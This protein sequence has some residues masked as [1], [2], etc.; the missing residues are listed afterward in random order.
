MSEF[1]HLRQRAVAFTLL[2]GFALFG[3][4]LPALGQDAPPARLRGTIDSVDG[5]LLV[6]KL[7][8][9]ASLKVRL[10]EKARISALVKASLA[11]VKPGT[12][13]GITSVPNDKGGQKALEIHVFPEAMRGR[14]EGQRPWDLAPQT[15]MTNGNIDLRVDA[16]AGSDLTLS[17]KGGTAKIEVPPDTTIVAFAESRPDDLRPGNKVIVFGLKKREDGVLE[18]AAIAIGRD[19]LTPP[20]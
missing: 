3:G 6:I 12:F 8:E 16:V 20:M 11:D 18:A 17:F 14:S 5:R 9:G 1:S 13:V 15:T 19:G 2:F 4:I 7:R 10:A